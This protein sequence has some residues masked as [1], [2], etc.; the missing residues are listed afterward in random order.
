MRSCLLKNPHRLTSGHFELVQADSVRLI[1]AKQY[2]LLYR[3]SLVLQSNEALH[4]LDIHPA[5]C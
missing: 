3:T 2:P 5:T 4:R 1:C